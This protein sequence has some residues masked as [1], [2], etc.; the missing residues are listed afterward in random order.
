[1]ERRF[2]VRPSLWSSQRSPWPSLKCY[3]REV[4]CFANL[5]LV[6]FIVHP[7]Q[8]RASVHHSLCS[9]P[10][11]LSSHIAAFRSLGVRGNAASH[12][13]SDKIE[14]S[15]L[16]DDKPRQ[17]LE[18]ISQTKF[19]NHSQTS[20]FDVGLGDFGVFRIHL[21]CN[22]PPVSRQRPREPDR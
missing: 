11:E 2:R 20:A 1:F 7:S 9:Q 3:M 16:L 17:L 21:E 14:R 5:C 6:H 13:R 8:E 15:A 19:D 12:P 18:F 10:S 22:Q 4:L